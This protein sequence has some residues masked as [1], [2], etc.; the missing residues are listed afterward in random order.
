MTLCVSIRSDVGKL[1]LLRQARSMRRLSAQFLSRGRDIIVDISF[2]ENG[3]AK[4]QRL[5]RS[6]N[7]QRA[8]GRGTPIMAS[9]DGAASAKVTTTLAHLSRVNAPLRRSKN[10]WPLKVLS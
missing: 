5:H 10:L 2:G 8:G 3:R 4:R 9:K 1:L 7:G 6:F